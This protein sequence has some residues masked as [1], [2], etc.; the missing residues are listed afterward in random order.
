MRTADSP[1]VEPCCK[2]VDGYNV[3]RRL[4]ALRAA[5]RRGLA[6]GRAALLNWLVPHFRDVRDRL[7]IVFD[8]DGVAETTEALRCG[9]GSQQVFTRRGE[10]ADAAILRRA[11][12]ERAAGRR[13][14]VVT[15]DLAVLLASA[16]LGAQG[17][18]TRAL[19]AGVSDGP[20]HLRKRAQQHQHAQRDLSGD[21]D[22]APAR[23]HPRKGN[24]RKAPRRRRG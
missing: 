22:D 6:E 1:G 3:I 19:R 9:A 16:G 14:E 15:D 17:V 8:G 11:A 24:P 12:T 7:V 20:R 10:S 5:E 13:V 23:L 18:G 21:A 2:L 4:P